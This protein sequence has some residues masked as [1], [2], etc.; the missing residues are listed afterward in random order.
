MIS[1]QE[2]ARHGTTEHSHEAKKMCGSELLTI[3][4][5]EEAEQ[6]A[7]FSAGTRGQGVSQIYHFPRICR[8]SVILTQG[9]QTIN[10]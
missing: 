2:T 7:P 1:P 10:N 4:L 3:I 6:I 9:C 5:V 8:V